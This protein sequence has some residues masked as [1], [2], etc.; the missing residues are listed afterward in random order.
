MCFLHIQ[1]S[2]STDSTN[3]GSCSTVVFTMDKL[4]VSGPA[5]FKPVFFKGQLH[6]LAGFH[7]DYN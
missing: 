5:Q 3:S 1:G 7:E 6:F 2:T 4:W